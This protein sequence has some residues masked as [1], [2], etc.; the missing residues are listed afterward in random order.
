MTRVQVRCQAT[1]DEYENVATAGLQIAERVVA[2]SG[3][4]TAG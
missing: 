3:G 1:V 4:P 2:S